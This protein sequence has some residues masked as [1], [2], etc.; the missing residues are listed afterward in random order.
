MWMYDERRIANVSY[1]VWLHR[2]SCVLFSLELVFIYD[3][4]NDDNISSHTKNINFAKKKI[5]YFIFILSVFY[6]IHYLDIMQSVFTKKRTAFKLK[7]NVDFMRTEINDF[8]RSFFF[9]DCLSL[10]DPMVEHVKRYERICSML[11]AR[12]NKTFWITKKI[13]K[14]REEI[15]LFCSAHFISLLDI[16]L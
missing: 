3:G 7:I 15:F 11:V 2:L 14:T 5:F 13:K 12:S 6:K 1:L 16:I 10:L 9:Y 8:V 4:L